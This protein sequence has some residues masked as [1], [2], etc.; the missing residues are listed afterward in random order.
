M[1]GPWL[2]FWQIRMLWDADMLK[3]S[4]LGNL[5]FWNIVIAFI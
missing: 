5:L 2:S 3:I 4:Q 1:M